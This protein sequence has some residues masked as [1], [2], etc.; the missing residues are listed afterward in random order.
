MDT[1]AK[2]KTT[3]S[4]IHPPVYKSRWPKI[5]KAF[6]KKMGWSQEKTANEIGVERRSVN[7][8]ERGDSIP[9]SVTV[10]LLA[11]LFERHAPELKKQMPKREI[12]KIS[13]PG[14]D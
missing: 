1:N 3:R 7:R 4:R 9:Q 5:L 10:K 2:S 6:R 14:I 8:W 13:P 12:R 11:M